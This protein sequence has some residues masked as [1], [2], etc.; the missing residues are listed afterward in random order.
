LFWQHFTYFHATNNYD[1]LYSM[2]GFGR[3]TVKFKDFTYTIEVRALNS[4][5]L[6]LKVKLP[7]TFKDKEMEVR[8]S[9]ENELL[10]GKVDINIESQ[11]KGLDEA[12]EID[13]T[14]LENYFNSYQE[15]AKKHNISPAEGLAQMTKLPNVLVSKGNDDLDALWSH[16]SEGIKNACKALM[17]FR[18]D[19]GHSLYKTLLENSTAIADNLKLVEKP[20]AERIPLVKERIL[21]KLQDF[22]LNDKLDQ[23]RLEQELIYYIEKFDIS[24]E[25]VRLAQHCQYFSEVLKNKDAQKGK[26]LG[27]IGQEMGREINTLGAKA[28]NSDIQKI[29]VS[30]KDALEKIKEQTANVL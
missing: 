3:E 10:R 21:S 27:F 29:V 28:N 26:K 4:K 20:E 19:E 17:Q 6:D 15:V 30:M 12:L 23:N 9:L 2:T 7:N 5:F 22:Q 1:M 11:T 16:I 13:A 8:K 25:K 14:A 24:E 18:E